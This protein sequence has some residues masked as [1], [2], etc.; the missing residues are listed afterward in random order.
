M[1]YV[2]NR[3]NSEVTFTLVAPVPKQDRVSLIKTTD[4]KAN[5]AD[6]PRSHIVGLW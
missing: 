3:H 2:L 5:L 6:L 4:I 1:P